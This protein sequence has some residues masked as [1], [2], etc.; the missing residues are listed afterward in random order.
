MIWLILWEKLQTRLCLKRRYCRGNWQH[1]SEK[2][3]RHLFRHRTCG[4]FQSHFAT[5]YQHDVQN[6]RI[7]CM[8]ELCENAEFWFKNVQNT[9]IH[10]LNWFTFQR[11]SAFCVSQKS[12]VQNPVWWIHLT[13]TLWHPKILTQNFTFRKMC[14]NFVDQSQHA[15]YVNSFSNFFTY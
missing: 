1:K 8:L 2:R 15:A 10:S 6:S 12:F 3:Y 14:W 7:W 9:W 4:F 11:H 5:E 13:T